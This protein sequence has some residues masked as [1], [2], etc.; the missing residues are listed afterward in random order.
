[1]KGIVLLSHGPLAKGMY[2]TT[3]WFM[4]PQI[5]Q[6]DYLCLEM[7]DSPEEFD[8]RLSQKIKEVDSGD[9]V[10]LIADLLGGTPCNRALLTSENGN[11]DLLAGMNLAM[12]LQLLGNRLSDN[13]DMSELES[14]ARQGV[15]YMNPSSAN[16]EDDFFAE[17]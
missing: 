16:E 9:G 3:G 15:S 8:E 14:V 11:V 7:E 12:V 2:E 4:G 5:P 6:Y 1:M 10:I 17:L 13:Y